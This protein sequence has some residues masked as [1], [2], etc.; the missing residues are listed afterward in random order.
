MAFTTESNYTG[1]GSE[2]D[3]LITFPF[4]AETDIKVQVDNVTQT[5]TTHYT[6]NNNIVTFGSAPADTK[7]VKLFRDTNI[8]KTS[9]VFQTGASIRAQDLNNIAKQF[10]YAAQE[11]EQASTTP[12]GTGLALTSGTKNHIQV[13]SAN[14]WTIVPGSVS[15]SLEANSID[16][17]HYVDGSIDRIHLEYDII[18]GTKLADNAVDSEHYTDGSVDLEHLASAVLTS[19]QG[20]YSNPV[21][22]VIWYAGSSAPTGYL[23]ANGDAIANGSGT[24]QSITADF[25][26]LYAV[27]GANLPDLRGEFIRGF[28]DG[29]GT[30]SGRS[31]R[32]T[33]S[34]ANKQHNHTATTSTKSLTGTL[35]SVAETWHNNGTATGVFTKTTDETGNNTPEHTDVSAT[36]GI[37]FDGSHDH[38]TTIANDGGSEA[39]PRNIAL[40]ACIKY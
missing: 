40:L 14:D 12:S 29:K 3:F 27:V 18:D 9:A 25:S 8:D 23:K 35:N 17:D 24:T 31:I 5:L 7:A 4:L 15:T 6:I 32:S 28:D 13:N 22:T 10:L 30:D 19:I 26:A 38:T 2:T 11:F 34:D 37:D 21:G 16:S 20:T 33:Q 36:G 39:R 1:D